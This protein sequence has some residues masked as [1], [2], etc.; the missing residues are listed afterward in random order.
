MKFTFINVA[1]VRISK[2]LLNIRRSK[3]TSDL[4]IQD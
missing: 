3:M 4:K 1:F 2:T